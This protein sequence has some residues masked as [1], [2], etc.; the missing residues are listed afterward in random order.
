MRETTYQP[1]GLAQGPRS[2]VPTL[3]AV[4]LTLTACTTSG[5]PVTTT[6]AAVPATSTTSA[7]DTTTTEAE[8]TTTIL[9][10]EE[11]DLLV[12]GSWGS[13]TAPEGSVAGAM[14]R[15]A[16]DHDIAAILTTGDNFYSDDA[17][18]LMRP[19]EWVSE[20]GVP[21]WITWGEIDGETDS[22]IAAIDQTF[23]SPPRWA[24][25]EWGAIDIVVLDSTQVR[26]DEQAGFLSTTLEDS[27]DPTIVLIH[28]PPLSCAADDDAPDTLDEWVPL[29]DSDVFLVLSGHENS[30]Q[31]FEDRGVTYLV[32]GGGG[33]Q[34][35]ELPECT[36]DEPDR[37]VGES[38]H[39]FLVLDQG[40]GLTVSAVD[41][42]GGT[43]DELTLTL[44]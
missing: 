30:Y 13:G 33:W 25:Y 4:C 20:A 43:F 6:T 26:A 40:E 42:T 21:F 28:H 15:Y 22:R 14:S 31:R 11:S 8:T 35:H 27:D 17:G 37:L 1:H 7:P 9:Q 34:L 41:V 36:G 18:F 39:H 32:S 24:L 3:L 38:L 19:F 10:P 12:V 23:G 5:E 29:F 16:E 44:P 2:L